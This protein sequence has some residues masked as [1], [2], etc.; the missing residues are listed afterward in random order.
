MVSYFVSSARRDNNSR[1]LNNLWA[2]SCRPFIQKDGKVTQSPPSQVSKSNKFFGGGARLKNGRRRAR[3]GSENKYEN[4]AHSLSIFK[5]ESEERWGQPPLAHCRRL[6]KRPKT[7]PSPGE[8]MAACARWTMFS[9]HYF[10]RPKACQILG[11]VMV[12]RRIAARAREWALEISDPVGSVKFLMP[13]ANYLESARAFGLR[14]TRTE[15]GVRPKCRNDY[16]RTAVP[17]S[18]MS[19]RALSADGKTVLSLCVHHLG[20]GEPCQPRK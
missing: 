15:L 9:S 12:L 10:P 3:T 4:R 14:T 11:R 13:S 19:E 1:L 6:W 20:V 17:W 5:T 8:F 2:Q 16:R 18:E 7:N